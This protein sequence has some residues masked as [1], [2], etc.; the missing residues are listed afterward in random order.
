MHERG[1][2]RLVCHLVYLGCAGLVST[3]SKA[4]KPRT[5]GCIIVPDMFLFRPD[6]TA[7]SNPQVL[8]PSADLSF[9]L[10]F[11]PP[12]SA[13]RQVVH[14]LIKL[15]REG[16]KIVVLGHSLGGGV[17]ALLGVLLKDV[18]TRNVPSRVF[19]RRKVN[20]RG[21]ASYE[22]HDPGGL[23]LMYFE[24]RHNLVVFYP[25]QSRCNRPCFTFYRIFAR[26]F[27]LVARVIGRGVRGK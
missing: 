24:G 15:H 3:H 27:F 2:R 25:C 21:W 4:Y 9:F 10:Y 14:H 23:G 8:V 5:L 22:A 26:S 12:L 18:R 16:H 6:S 11:S 17:A 20:N 19:F 13:P 1:T 7:G